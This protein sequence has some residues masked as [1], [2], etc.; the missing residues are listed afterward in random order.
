MDVLIFLLVIFAGG[1]AGAIA[2]GAMAATLWKW[3]V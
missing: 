1:A 3:L 2:G